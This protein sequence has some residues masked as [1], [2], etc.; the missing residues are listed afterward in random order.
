MYLSKWLQGI[1]ECNTV[2]KSVKVSF[3][4]LNNFL[5]FTWIKNF[6]DS[7]MKT[8]FILE[9]PQFICF[10]LSW[11][12]SLNNT[13]SCKCLKPCRF[14]PSSPVQ[15]FLISTLFLICSSLGLVHAVRVISVSD[16]YINTQG[17]FDAG[18]MQIL[19]L[20][21]FSTF[22]TFCLSL[23]LCFIL[24]SFSP[25]FHLIGHTRNGSDSF[26]RKLHPLP[27]CVPPH[28]PPSPSSSTPLLRRLRE[29]QWCC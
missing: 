4:V 24:T 16:S 1:F 23:R 7:S 13:S 29:E 2:L 9:I 18:L 6:W 27:V 19:G 12:I 11:C 10:Y 14:R 28:L 15:A 5:F 3:S 20:L 26:L 21:I 17:L 22:A 25:S 8:F